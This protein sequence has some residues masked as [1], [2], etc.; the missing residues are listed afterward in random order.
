MQ[1]ILIAHRGNTKGPNLKL[2]N[3]PDYIESALSEGFDAE[4]DVW[5]VDGVLYLGHDHPSYPITIEFLRRDRIW[6]HAKH[7]E[8]LE[9]L[10][11]N[12]CHVFSHDRDDYILTSKGFI[13]AYPGVKLS[14]HTVAV[15]PERTVYTD[16]ELQ[17]CTGICSDFVARYF[18]RSLGVPRQ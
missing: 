1:Q 18:S 7:L 15:M 5:Y 12:K 2:E 14:G 10:L 13:W 16:A 4:V 6:C 3:Q 9:F 11:Q 17:K 8:A